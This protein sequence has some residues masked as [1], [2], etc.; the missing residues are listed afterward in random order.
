MEIRNCFS[1]TN[2]EG[3]SSPP[4]FS[5][6]AQDELHNRR[7]ALF[8]I[9]AT[10]EAP[11]APQVRPPSSRREIEWCHSRDRPTAFANAVIVADTRTAD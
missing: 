4:L 2:A 3:S 5:E 11:P 8:H 6:L 9:D 10:L 1:L 7:C